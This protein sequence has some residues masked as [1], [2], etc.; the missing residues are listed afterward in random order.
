MAFLEVEAAPNNAARSCATI[1]A[2]PVVWLPVSC[3]FCR[4]KDRSLARSPILSTPR[5]FKS[6]SESEST[7]S[8]SICLSKNL[9]QKVPKLNCC[10]ISSIVHVK[11]GK[12]PI[13][14]A[15]LPH[16][17]PVLLHQPEVAN[18][19]W[20]SRDYYPN[21]SKA[22]RKVKVEARER[23]AHRHL[24]TP[25]RTSLFAPSSVH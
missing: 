19:L 20:F 16:S 4:H 14:R 23:R 10:K 12:V 3:C 17:F 15:L 6:W 22:P 13:V 9:W 1:V 11:T 8:K 25:P 18:S 21:N 5:R 24:I 7:L 2:R